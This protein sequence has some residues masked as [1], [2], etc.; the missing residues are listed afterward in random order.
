MSKKDL[1][2]AIVN[3]NGQVQDHFKEIMTLA[4]QNKRQQVIKGIKLASIP[5]VSHIT[6][7]ELSEEQMKE[8]N[9]LINDYLSLFNKI[10][11]Y[12][13]KIESTP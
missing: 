1:D 3:D 4:E 8:G 12:L 2:D 11:L 6:D 13:K 9:Q 5:L 7:L 10:K